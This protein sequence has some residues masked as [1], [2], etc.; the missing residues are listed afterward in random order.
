MKIHSFIGWGMGIVGIFG[1]AACSSSDDGDRKAQ[2]P[3]VTD[4][5]ERDAVIDFVTYGSQLNVGYS[6]AAWFMRGRAYGPGRRETQVKEGDCTVTRWEYVDREDPEHPPVFVS[7][8]EIALSGG[9][10]PPNSGMRHSDGSYHPYYY[11]Y[12]HGTDLL[13]TGGEDVRIAAAGSP[14]GVGPFEA[15]LKA[16][17]HIS[18]TT[19]SWDEGATIDRSKDL[20][21][22][23]TRSGAASGTIEVSL[24]AWA[25]KHRSGVDVLCAYPAS[26]DAV[27]VPASVLQAL[28]AGTSGSIL[29][30]AA[31]RQTITASSWKVNLRLRTGPA[32]TNGRHT[33]GPVTFL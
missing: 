10:I 14:N 6:A 26:R 27:V 15:S 33:S 23:W 16:P 1:I 17:S 4:D 24:G 19:P 2:T 3:L 12:F 30:E 11:P 20:E 28:P 13:W 7:A 32:Q 18:L 31:E 22:A 29:I 8:G 5:E 9:K 21:V 25:E